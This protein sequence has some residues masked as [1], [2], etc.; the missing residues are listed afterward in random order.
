MSNG[1]FQYCK[2]DGG[3]EE[4][5]FRDCVKG[6]VGDLESRDFSVRCNQKADGSG[7]ESGGV[8]VVGGKRWV[9]GLVVFGLV[10]MGGVW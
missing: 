3:T 10:W 9:L 5:D 8:R 4:K 6:H 1:C 2:V 7:S